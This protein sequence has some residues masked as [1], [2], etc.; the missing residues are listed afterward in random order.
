[1]VLWI[2]SK[3]TTELR[4]ICENE[5]NGETSGFNEINKILTTVAPKIFNFDYPI[6]DEEYRVPLEVKI[7]RT[8]YTR[9]I[10][11]E[12]V[13]LWKLR[14]QNKLCNIMPYYNQLYK[15]ALLEFDVFNDV[16]YTEVNDGSTHDN[17][18]K[19]INFQNLGGI[20]TNTHR[21]NGKEI[22]KI[23]Y[24]GGST[25]TTSYEGKET[26]AIDYT[27]KETNSIDYT[28]KETNST[29]YTGAEKD[30]SKTSGGTTKTPASKIT[31]KSDTPQG[32]L[33][34]FISDDY[35]TTAQ[36]ETYTSNETETYNN[37]TNSAEKSFTDRNDTSTKSFTARNDTSTKS[38]TGRNDTSTK[39]FTGRNDTS[40]KSFT[41]RNDTSTKEF[42]N[43]KDVNTQQ[44]SNRN[45]VNT[46]EFENRS[47][48]IMQ[49]KLSKNKTDENNDNWHKNDNTLTVK[50]KRNNLTYA[51]MLQKYRETFLNID[52]MVIDELSDLFFGLW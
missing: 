12:T 26:N 4:F 51:E 16:D 45:D 5:Y 52:K 2:M 3:Y 29:D 21:K 47:D 41:G 8:Y 49:E 17:L 19:I 37:L 42:Q 20:D 18:K 7:L 34:G 14:L 40:T 27:G 35:L 38:F 1:M 24:K 22:S 50:G 11:E 32:G 25:N 15:S 10:C 33:N 9:E 44:F 23:D 30:V 46:L 28:G 48:V 43:R 31:T 36:K 6:F 13:G 39:S